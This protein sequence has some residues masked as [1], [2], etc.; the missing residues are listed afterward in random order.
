MIDLAVKKKT[1][2]D[3][4]KQITD[5]IKYLYEGKYNYFP[6]LRFIG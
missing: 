3:L 5:R 4:F 2:K 6:S 1:V